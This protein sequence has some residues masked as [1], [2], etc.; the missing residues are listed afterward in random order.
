MLQYKSQ[1]GDH[2][3]DRNGCSTRCYLELAG[4]CGRTVRKFKGSEKANGT[5]CTVFRKGWQWR[6][7]V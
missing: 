1:N 4:F 2:G 3:E 7:R 6:L 5:D